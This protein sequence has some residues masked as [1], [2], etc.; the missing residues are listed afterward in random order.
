MNDLLF[1]RF[2]SV[3]LEGVDGFRKMFVHDKDRLFRID[4]EVNFDGAM[5]VK[6]F[7]VSSNTASMCEPKKNKSEK[8]EKYAKVKL[9]AGY[10]ADFGLIGTGDIV[11]SIFSKSGVDKVLSISAFHKMDVLTNPCSQK[12][13][14]G[15]WTAIL[16]DFLTDNGLSYYEILSD[17]GST[18][19]SQFAATGT[20]GSVIAKICKEIKAEAYFDLG[21]LII[22]TKELKSELAS[23]Q[24]VL[25]NSSG[26]VGSPEKKNNEWSVKSLLN[27]RIG[28]N[29]MVKVQFWDYSKNESTTKQ[30]LVTKGKHSGSSWTSN[31]YTEF[32]CKPV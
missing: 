19:V 21:K 28:K 14:S 8:I 26:L 12:N 24:V 10:G 4:F 32:E 31:F 3:E 22:A 9:L 17:I 18:Q 5:T 25:D 15:T 30:F 20:V 29:K 1:S 2:V 11:Q 7:N 27:R 13:Y 6:L 16:S 23:M